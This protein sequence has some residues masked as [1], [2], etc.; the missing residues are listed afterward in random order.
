M[1]P[2]GQQTWIL[3]EKWKLKRLNC[4]LTINLMQSFLFINLHKTKIFLLFQLSF[5]HWTKNK[6]KRRWC[7]KWG[8]AQEEIEFRHQFITSLSFHRS[9]DLFL[10]SSERSLHIKLFETVQEKSLFYWSCQ[11]ESA[12][13][14]WHHL[15]GFSF[16]F[17]SKISEQEAKIFDINFDKLENILKVVSFQGHQPK[18]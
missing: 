11:L 5:C 1:K 10:F 12:D 16:V 14:L 6:C 9:Y 8:M 7:A 15:L 17:S 18:R 2:F 13:I 3:I 4:Q